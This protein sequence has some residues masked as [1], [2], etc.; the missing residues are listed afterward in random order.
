[1][2]DNCLTHTDT[3]T[4]T[5]DW[6]RHAQQIYYNS[7]CLPNMHLHKHSNKLQIHSH[8]SYRLTS[9]V[10]RVALSV[11]T[12]EET[13]WAW[14]T[15]GT[16]QRVCDFWTRYTGRLACTWDVAIGTVHWNSSYITPY[17]SCSCSN[18]ALKQFTLHGL[19]LINGCKNS[20]L[21]QFTLHGLKLIY[22]CKNG[23]LKQL[24]LHGLY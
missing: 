10:G 19:K 18:S 14:S 5:S 12:R 24:T 1:M 9:A 23:A 15:V 11:T 3:N 20:A 17:L 7:G 21:K 13:R 4:A 6:H 2:T 8:T 16:V 22:G